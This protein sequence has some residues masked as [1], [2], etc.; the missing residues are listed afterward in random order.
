MAKQNTD[1]TAFDDLKGAIRAKSVGNLYFFHGEEM[2]LLNY[3][4]EQ[5]KKLLLDD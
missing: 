1:H 5:L 2:F 4:L 3:Y